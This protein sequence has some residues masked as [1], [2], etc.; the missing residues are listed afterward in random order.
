[1]SVPAS[2]FHGIFAEKP[3]IAAYSGEADH[4]FRFDGDHYSE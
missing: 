1:V 4:R 3:Q 2:E